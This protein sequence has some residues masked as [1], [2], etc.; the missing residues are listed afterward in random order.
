MEIKQD[1]EKF[2][3]G[4]N[5]DAPLAEMTIVLNGPKQLIIDHTMVSDELRGQGV[6]DQLL[7]EVVQYAR[8][9]N[10]KIIPLC[11]FAKGHKDR[12]STRLN[13][14]HV[15]ISYAVFCLKKKKNENP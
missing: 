11:P 13:S 7:E 6:G 5:A 9:N 8:D 10:R 12:K 2:Y 3:V 14:S 1:N 4:D 15:A